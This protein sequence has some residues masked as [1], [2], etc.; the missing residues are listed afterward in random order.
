MGSRNQ[1]KSTVPK[2]SRGPDTACDDLNISQKY[3]IYSGNE[4]FP[5]GHGALAINIHQFIELIK[6]KITVR[7][8][9]NGHACYRHDYL[10]SHCRSRSR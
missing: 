5:L 9:L 8:E 1:K 4:S 3:V 2:L 7:N 6:N 10:G